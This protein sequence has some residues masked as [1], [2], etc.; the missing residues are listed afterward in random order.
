MDIFS[1]REFI[2]RSAILAAA[3][4]AGPVVGADSKPAP[5]AAARGAEKLRVAVVGV[6][7]RGM[8]HVSGFLNKDVNCE[9]TTVCDCDEAVIG[10]AMKKIEAAQ[11]AAPKYEKDIRKVIADKDIDVVSIATPNHWHAL[12]AVWAMESGK[13][14]YVEKPATH[15]V[16]EGAIMLAAARKYKRICQVG[17][18]SRSNPGMRDAIAFVRG[19]KIGKVD[20]AIGLC[21][22]TR[23]SIGDTGLKMGEQKPPATMD[24]DLWCGPAPLTMPK[25]KTGNGTVH[26]DWHWFWDFGNGDLG[27]QG[28]HEMDK[29]RWGLGQTRLP[30][31]ALSFGGRFGYTD[32]GETANTQLC[33]FDYGPAAK[34]I[35][36]VRGLKTESY[37]GAMVGNI[38]VGTDGYVVCPSYGGGIAYDKDGKETQRF[39]WI[40]DE[41]AAQGG[42]FGGSDQHHFDNYAKAVRSRKHEDLNCDISEGHLSASLCH[43]ANISYRLGREMPIATA[44]IFTN[45]KSFNE[46]GKGLVAHLKANKVDTEK[47]LGRFGYPLLIDT[48]SQT[49]KNSGDDEVTAK[50]NAMLFREYRKGFELKEIA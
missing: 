49:I 17:T 39:G 2:N 27:N 46:F 11:K 40:K 21:Y 10:S 20:L 8:S 24:Y 4:A 14:V 32:D 1:R 31:Y 41:K 25:R 48:R 3:A 50:A 28:V 18:Q 12:M 42:R 36:E 47:T 19:G 33:L 13:D 44:E 16:H 23:N 38:F 30:Q 35:F 45:N 34:M 5:T 26:Y 6:R 7:G 29:A 43:L 37:K 9:I 15:N 22:K